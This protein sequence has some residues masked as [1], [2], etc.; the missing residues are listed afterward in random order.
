MAKS[1]TLLDAMFNG[2][3]NKYGEFKKS[4]GKREFKPATFQKLKELAAESGLKVTNKTSKADVV[5]HFTGFNA[6]GQKVA[7]EEEE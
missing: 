1:M 4:K 3:C 2:L 6:D 7:A 5:E